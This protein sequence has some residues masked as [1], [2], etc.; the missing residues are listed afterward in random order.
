MEH[1]LHLAAKHFIEAIVPTSHMSNKD[2][3][4]GDN[5]SNDDDKPEFASGDSL[6]KVLALVKQVWHI[7]GLV[8]NLNSS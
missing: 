4:E 2:I 6:G 1:S 5:D 8:L 3:F 7:P